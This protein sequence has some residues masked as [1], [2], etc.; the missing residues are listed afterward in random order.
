MKIHSITLV[1][2]INIKRG[3][4]NIYMCIFFCGFDYKRF[5]PLPYITLPAKAV[6]S[7]LVL[8]TFLNTSRSHVFHSLSPVFFSTN[9]EIS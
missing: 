4:F 9:S 2:K 6:V 1:V 5:L 8:A 3:N 7:T